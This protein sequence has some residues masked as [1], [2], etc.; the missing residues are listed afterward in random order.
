MAHIGPQR[1]PTLTKG[2]HTYLEIINLG[3][4]LKAHLC[5]ITKA[6]TKTLIPMDLEITEEETR[7]LLLHLKIEVHKETHILILLEITVDQEETRTLLALLSH[8]LTTEVL[9]GT[10]ILHTHLE[11]IGHIEEI[12]TLPIPLTEAPKETHFL[13]TCLEIIEELG[14]TLILLAYLLIV[15]ALSE[16]LTFLLILQEIAED[17]VKIQTCLL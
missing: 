10:L 9:R 14:E 5:L 7:T 17:P 13:L 11:I 2:L 16:K 1:V 3:G 12:L 6:H 8:L 15:E 4:T